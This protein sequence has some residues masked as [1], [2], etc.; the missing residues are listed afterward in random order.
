MG[1][2][3]ATVSCFGGNNGSINLTTTGG[4]APYTYAWSTGANTED[5]S[6]LTAG[7]YNV[8]VTDAQNCVATV[9]VNVL[10]PAVINLTFVG[11]NVTTNGGTNGS[12][13]LSV[14]GGTTPFTYVWSNGTTTQDLNN[15]PA[16]NYCVTVTDVNGCTAAGCKLITEPACTGFSANAAA[17][18][19]NCNGG[20]NGTATLTVVGV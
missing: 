4:V 18:N 13:D 19:V 3:P 1:G 15:I 2:V 14:V 10:Q 9:G 6:G 11:V 17:T 20:N 8:T 7:L 5:I 16:G 12:I